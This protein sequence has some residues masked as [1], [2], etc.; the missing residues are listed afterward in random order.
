M[1]IIKTALNNTIQNVGENGFV[2]RCHHKN[3]SGPK[4][5]P[6]LSA[7]AL[8]VEEVEAKVLAEKEAWKARVAASRELYPLNRGS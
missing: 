1:T 8:Y 2:V 3:Y 5:F 7:A 6:T 4:Y